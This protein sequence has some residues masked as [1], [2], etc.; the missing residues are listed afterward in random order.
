MDFG[1]SHYAIGVR[2]D[3]PKEV[4]DTLSYWLNVLMSCSPLDPESACQDGNL[5]TFFKGRGG[6]GDECG[7]V[8]YP[9][10]SEYLSSGAIAGVV[11]ASVSCAVAFYTIFHQYRLR[12]Q[13]EVYAQRTQ[14]AVGV[15][16]RER[17]FERQLN[18]FL[19]H[20]IRNPISSALAALSFVSAK[21]TDPECIPSDE[22]RASLTSDIGVID[23]SL[24]FVNE[25]LRNML[26]LNRS[27]DNGL[28][29]HYA[30]TD[31]LRDV[32]DPVV[33]ILFMR[34]ALVDVSADCP[35]NLIISSDRMRLKQICLNLATN[36]TKFVEQGYI[37]LRAEV[38]RG[39]VQIHVEDSG[40]GIPP[41]KRKQLF[42][43]FQASL[44]SLSQ[45]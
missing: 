16:A 20:E 45:G 35:K 44:D 40:P 6:N 43:K 9:T 4:V 28:T 34:G 11:V 42:A 22:N 38:V 5:A 8:L 19:S 13:K 14:A 23:A 15:A 17:D 41:E 36:S 25:L 29:L 26:D 21:A 2:R 7:Y 24:Q 33:S 12:L 3:I 1:L 39:S 30:P 31:I 32:F 18:E 27:T 37:R 10:T